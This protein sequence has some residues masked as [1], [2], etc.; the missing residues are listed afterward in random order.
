MEFL[1]V[2]LDYFS[3]LTKRIAFYEWGGP[4]VI[5]VTSG[6]LSYIHDTDL[7]YEII[8]NAIP[9]I[10]T[11]LGFTLAALTLFLTGNSKI[12]E[13]KSFMTEKK[14]S[15][16]KISLY[17]LIVISYSY[18]ILIETLL[19]IGYYIGSLFPYVTNTYICVVANTLFIILMLNVLF[20]TIRSITDLYFVITRHE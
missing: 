3:T 5:G 1:F 17:K 15:G 9:V 6:V 10:A 14:I 8:Q 19:C 4:F 18:L 12:E 7:L 20:S 13:A 11:L 2:I 16:V